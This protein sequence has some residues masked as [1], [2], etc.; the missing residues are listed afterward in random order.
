M[1]EVWNQNPSNEVK[2]FKKEAEKGE[3]WMCSRVP[4]L[5]QLQTDKLIQKVYSH[6]RAPGKRPDLEP[7]VS[8][9]PLAAIYILLN[10]EN[11]SSK[12]WNLVFKNSVISGKEIIYRDFYPSHLVRWQEKLRTSTIMP[13]RSHSSVGLW[14]ISCTTK[15]YRLFGVC[16]VFLSLRGIG[17]V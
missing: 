9:W 6:F 14:Q 12:W 8:F 11:K 2:A 13:P 16:R 4:V 1:H 17:R 15:K 10:T 5:S 7:W 3:N